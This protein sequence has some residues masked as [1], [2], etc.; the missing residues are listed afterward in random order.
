MA[1]KFDQS[2]ETLKT[3]LFLI[4]SVYKGKQTLQLINSGLFPRFY[5]K[6]GMM[7]L[8]VKSCPEEPVRRLVTHFEDTCTQQRCVF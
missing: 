8:N 4:L 1:T 3:L 5:W 7:G 2:T 6:R